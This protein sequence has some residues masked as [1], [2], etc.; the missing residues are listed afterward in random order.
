MLNIVKSHYYS[1]PGIVSGG[2][3]LADSGRTWRERVVFQSTPTWD[4]LIV[5]I[6]HW[7][8]DLPDVYVA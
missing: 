1:S 3:I 6:V 2:R 7:L 5:R 8:F 4:V